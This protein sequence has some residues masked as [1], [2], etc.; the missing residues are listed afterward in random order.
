M[1]VRIRAGASFQKRRVQFHAGTCIRRST[2]LHW[3]SGKVSDFVPLVSGGRG[4]EELEFR[5]CGFDRDVVDSSDGTGVRADG[6]R[7]KRRR[8]HKEGS[9]R[10][11]PRRSEKKR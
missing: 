8:I 9:F 7:S 11:E 2:Y 4:D 6:A 5:G 1:Y 10:L 3:R